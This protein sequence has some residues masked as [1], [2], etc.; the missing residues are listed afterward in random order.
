MILKMNDK[1]FEEE[2]AKGFVAE[3]KG[4]FPPK[5][6]HKIKINLKDLK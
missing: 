1:K 6:G 3:F 2:K 4:E 5:K